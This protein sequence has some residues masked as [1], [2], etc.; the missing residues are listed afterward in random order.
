MYLL[1]T[2]R[3]LLCYSKV[4]Y[5]LPHQ[6]VFLYLT[7][8]NFTQSRFVS[9]VQ[10][11][12][13]RTLNINMITTDKLERGYECIES[14]KYDLNTGQVAPIFKL[15]KGIIG[16]ILSYT[17]VQDVITFSTVCR[18][19]HQWID[20]NKLWRVLY[21]R[22]YGRDPTTENAKSELAVKWHT[23]VNMRKGCQLNCNFDPRTNN[24]NRV[25]RRSLFESLS[26]S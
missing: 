9:F 23:Q 15:A 1:T 20:N 19:C 22:E 4:T 25:H 5:F 21:K 10:I 18:Q 13:N 11:S 16:G 3:D 7:S 12:F 26:T 2:S 24:D 8:R 14:S 6:K 17:S